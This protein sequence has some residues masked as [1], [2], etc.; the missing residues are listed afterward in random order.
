MKNSPEISVVVPVFNEE[1]NVVRL[2]AEILETMKKLGNSFEIIFIDDGSADATFSKIEHLKPLKIIS[3]RKNFGQTAALDAGIKAS[4]GKL[5]I[6]MDGDLQNDPADIPKLIAHLKK[7]DFDVVSGWRRKRKDPISKR[8]ISKVA[9]KLRKMLIDDGIHDSGCTLKVYKKE[10]FQNI[11]LMGEIH[12]FI[13]ATL[14]IYG[15]KVGEVE[16]NHRPRIH[17]VTK[18]NY[19]R[20]VKGFL[21]MLGVWFWRK[22][23]GRPLHLFGGLGLLSFISGSIFFVALFIAR[24]FFN[25]ALYNKIWPLLAVFLILIGIQLFISG[26]MAD[27]LIK[28]YYKGRHMNY[29]IKEEIEND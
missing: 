20:T 29:S 14:I 2:H 26:L 24:F 11:D 27:I 18:Y 8:I 25:Y 22:Y 1:G 5:I 3:F 19:R 4:G 13:P 10:C 9:E 17:G 12:R 16:V 6:S 21:D 28:G 15:F 7:G 23:A